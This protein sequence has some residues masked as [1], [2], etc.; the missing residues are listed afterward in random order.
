MLIR[1][2]FEEWLQQFD[3]KLHIEEVITTYLDQK[4]GKRF[5]DKNKDIASLYWGKKRIC[6]IPAK[7][8]YSKKWTDNISDRRSDSGYR[9]SDDI[10]HRSLSGVG[11]ILL[12]KKIIT[13]KQFVTHFITPRNKAL[14]ERMCIRF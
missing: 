8:K 10:E 2:T 9:T 5:R 3:G 13:P 4:T 1:K 12:N 6:S 7:L 11:L 14:L